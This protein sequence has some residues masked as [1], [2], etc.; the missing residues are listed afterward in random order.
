MFVHGQ[1]CGGRTAENGKTLLLQILEA[2]AAA[3]QM[4]TGRV[5]VYLIDLLPA[6]MAEF[7]HI[8]PEPGEEAVWPA[9]LPAADRERFAKIGR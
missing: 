9:A 8:L 7:G 6:Q 3:A 1:I 5:W 2:A 4:P